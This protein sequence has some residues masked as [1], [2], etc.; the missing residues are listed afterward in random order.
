MDGS[1]DMSTHEA[2]SLQT[3]LE[4]LSEATEKQMDGQDLEATAATRCFNVLSG[5]FRRCERSSGVASRAEL[6]DALQESA[7]VMGFLRLG[8]DQDIEVLLPRPA[9][10][11]DDVDMTWAEFYA[12]LA[13]ETMTNSLTS[14]GNMTVPLPEVSQAPSTDPYRYVN[15]APVIKNRT[16]YMSLDQLILMCKELQIMPDL[17]N[18]KQIV[19]IFKRSQSM[20]LGSHTTLGSSAYGYLNKEAFEIAAGE[21]ALEAYSVQPFSDEYPQAHEKLHAF[22]CSV[23]PQNRI[24]MQERCYYGCNGRGR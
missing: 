7:E 10:A 13:P 18:R 17:L 9:E 4:A 23:L 11:T 12:H 14:A 24:E 20:V 8:R 19:K 16:Q 5:I 3:R 2:A 15:G 22:F 6:I 21:L 1:T